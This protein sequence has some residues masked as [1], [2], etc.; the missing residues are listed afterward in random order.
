MQIDADRRITPV[1]GKT[2]RPGRSGYAQAA[3][4]WYPTLGIKEHRGIL[5]GFHGHLCI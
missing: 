3:Q 4:E 1:R 2:Q 5:P